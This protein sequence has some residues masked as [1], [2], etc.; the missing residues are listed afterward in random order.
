MS[1]TAE[2]KAASSAKAE[3]SKVTEVKAK[4]PVIPLRID[5]AAAAIARTTEFDLRP[6]AL[7]HL[8]VKLSFILCVVIPTLCGAIYFAFIASDRYAAG[9][10]FSVRSMDSSVAG[11]DFLGAITGLSSVGTTTTDS[12]ILLEYLRSRELLESLREDIDFQ[13]AYG[14]EDVDFFY[15]LDVSAPIED[16]VAYWD[17]MIS[18]SYDNTSSILTFEVQAFSPEDAERVADLIVG[19]SQNLINRLS[20]QARN[21]AVEFAKK[22]VASAELRL[23]IIREEMR[24]FRSTSNAIDPTA[25][26]AAQ[27]ELVAGIERELIDLR[28][29]LG[30]MLTSLDPDA[31][32]VRQ[33]RQQIESLEQELRL[34]QNEVGVRTSDDP[35]VGS[36][37][38]GLLADYERLKVE[39]EFAQQAYATALSSLERARM[40]ADR[41]QRFLAVFKSPS[42]PQQA[43][44]PQRLLNTGL[45]FLVALIL[46]SIGVLIAY[47]IRDHMR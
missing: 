43:I 9:A 41:Q 37:L 14:G 19:Y 2:S 46:W 39:Q 45:V 40:E 30:S 3:T 4:A 6:R 15:R 36:N 25:S 24:D 34:K 21:D 29:R 26:A 35:S 13:R 38:S 31:P 16:I 1:E 23:K 44:Y 33:I 18:T 5:K 20:E 10:G 7:R 28:S 42:L 47:S 17:W 22:E 27:V 8:A 11:G 32:S 12:Y